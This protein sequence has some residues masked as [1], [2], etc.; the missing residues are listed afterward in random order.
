MK[1]YDLKAKAGFFQTIY[2]L[3]CY[4]I[5]EKDLLELGWEEIIADPKNLVLVEWPEKIQK[6]WPKKYLKIAFRVRGEKERE[7]VVGR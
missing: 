1:K 6:I 3:D 5:G 7:I 4:R 2:H